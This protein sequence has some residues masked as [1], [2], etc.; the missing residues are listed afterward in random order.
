[1]DWGF[2]PFL[3]VSALGMGGLSVIVTPDLERALH[4]GAQLDVKLSAVTGHELNPAVQ[5]PKYQ[6][7]QRLQPSLPRCFV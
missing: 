5:A 1:M 2:L 7:L 4:G 3:S 6:G